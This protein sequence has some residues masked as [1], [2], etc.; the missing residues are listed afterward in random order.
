[1]RRN[2]RPARRARDRGHGDPTPRPRSPSTRV[3]PVTAP[4]PRCGAHAVR[5]RGR[6][7]HRVPE[8]PV[9]FGFSRELPVRR[10]RPPD[11]RAEPGPRAPA[12]R[13]P[14]RARC[15][16]R[17]HEL[18]RSDLGPR[19]GRDRPRAGQPRVRQRSVLDPARVLPVLRPRREGTRRARLLLLRRRRVSRRPVLA[20]DLAELRALLRG[21]RLRGGGRSVGSRAGEPDARVA[22][23]GPR[24]PSR[25]AVPLHPRL[26]APPAVLVLHGERRDDHG[27]TALAAAARGARRRRAE[28]SLAQLP[29][30]GPDGPERRPRPRDG[31]PRVRRGDR[32]CEPLRPAVRHRARQPRR[33][34]GGRVRRPEAHVEGSTATRWR[35]VS[36]D[37]QPAFDDASEH[38]VRCV[39]ATP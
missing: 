21:R 4:N 24:R 5:H 28:R 6:G 37:G 2:P 17:L 26:L 29:A 39:R 30:L 1:M 3:R 20:P 10:H 9:R 25:L 27:G 38:A 7:R 19:E 33:G 15:V 16:R 18:L 11:R 32:G 31:D 23:E 22:R 13:Q 35:W 12:R 34:A 14:V 36:A 8:R